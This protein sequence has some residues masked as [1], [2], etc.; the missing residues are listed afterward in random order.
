MGRNR[1]PPAQ[2]YYK[3]NAEWKPKDERYATKRC[4]GQAPVWP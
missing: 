2:P 1:H 3:A 4:K